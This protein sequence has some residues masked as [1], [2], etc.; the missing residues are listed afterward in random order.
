MDG[1]KLEAYCDEIHKCY[2]PSDDSHWMYIGILFV[3][4]QI[5]NRLLT[6][7]WYGTEMTDTPLYTVRMEQAS[8]EMNFL[9]TEM[10]NFTYTTGN[11]YTLNYDVSG[12][13]CNGGKLLGTCSNTQCGPSCW[14]TCAGFTCSG[15]PTCS[16]TCP[17]WNTCHITCSGYTCV[18]PCV[19]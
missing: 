14:N 11:G 6:E 13:C 4:L 17:K 18:E 15:E 2:L 16:D 3:P 8:S 1:I 9:S 12:G 7:L 19:P 10:N 5:K